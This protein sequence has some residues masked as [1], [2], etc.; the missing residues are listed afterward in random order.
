MI[1][2]SLSLVSLGW[3]GDI[4]GNSELDSLSVVSLFLLLGGLDSSG[5][6]LL[7]E[8][9]F[10]LLLTLHLVDGFNQDSLVLEL[11]TLGGQVEVMINVLGNLLCFS[12][13]LEKSSEDSLSSH[14]ENLAW[15]SGVL[16]TLSLTDAGVSALSLGFVDPLDAR[17]GVHVHMLSHDKTIL[18]KF[19][20]I[21][22]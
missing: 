20:D 13:L 15:H 6:S 2:V 11:V 17:L 18:E 9:L 12:V 19:S 10:S 4:L 7:G 3:L 1:G 14:P 8:F 5:L 22:S 21:F 16:G